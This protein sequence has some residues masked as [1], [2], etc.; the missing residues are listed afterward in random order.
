M[1]Q[2]R[3]I[4]ETYAFQLLQD[5]GMKIL[6]HVFV[7]EGILGSL[8]CR[9]DAGIQVLEVLGEADAHFEGIH[10]G[11]FANQSVTAIGD[12]S[13]VALGCPGFII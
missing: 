8:I 7:L 13:C 6:V 12:W 2:E 10:V 5:T 4:H 9:R 11:V 1:K 3:P